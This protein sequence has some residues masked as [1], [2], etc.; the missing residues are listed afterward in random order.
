MLCQQISSKFNILILSLLFWFS[1]VFTP[2]LILLLVLLRSCFWLIFILLSSSWIDIVNFH[3]LL[4]LLFYIS[5]CGLFI[6]SPYLI[7]LVF[8]YLFYPW[9]F[10]RLFQGFSSC[11]ELWNIEDRHFLNDFQHFDEWRFEVSINMIMR[12]I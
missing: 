9:L 4:H 10:S 2:Y 12:C 5:L 7:F 1:F 8:G 11:F 3:F 6:K